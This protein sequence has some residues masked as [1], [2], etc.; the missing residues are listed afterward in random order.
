MTPYNEDTATVWLKVSYSVCS[1]QMLSLG[2]SS[3][4]SITINITHEL[5]LGVQL[6]M[7][8]Y[9]LLVFLETAGPR[10]QGRR[11]YVFNSFLIMILYAIGAV[12]DEYSMF[13][14]LFERQGSGLRA[15]Q[16]NRLQAHKWWWLAHSACGSAVIW[17]G[18]GLLVREFK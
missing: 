1:M 9:G 17:A 2:K 7:S 4:N 18:D 12:G 5:K 11:R 13:E 3:G 15:V 6:F 14:T 16:I 10:R 8:I